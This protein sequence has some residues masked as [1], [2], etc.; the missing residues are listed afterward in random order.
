MA[1]R[2]I[3][4]T[5]VS[6]WSVSGDCARK[7]LIIRMRGWW[8]HFSFE[9]KT[10]SETGRRTIV[11]LLNPSISLWVRERYIREGE[12]VCLFF[13][14]SSLSFPTINCFSFGSRVGY[15]SVC[16]WSGVRM[17]GRIPS[18][19]CRSREKAES[20][21]EDR[22]EKE[23]FA[24]LWEDSSAAWES[25]GREILSIHFFFLWLFT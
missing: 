1:W 8:G 9:L 19:R 21:R 22:Q 14:L 18:N 20:S 16:N 15:T 24:R 25:K 5:S 13:S 10:R 17:R 7:L 2:W 23:E 11:N 6:E 12:I 3:H 4:T